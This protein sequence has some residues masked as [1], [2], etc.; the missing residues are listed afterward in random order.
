MQ[1]PAR[2]AAADDSRAAL[3][4]AAPS[5]P[6]NA[7]LAAPQ[8]AASSPA[9]RSPFF[10]RKQSLLLFPTDTKPVSL[11]LSLPTPPFFFFFS[12]F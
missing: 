1:R 11:S 5:A 7:A 4:C 10:K 12:F 3:R 8:N 9:P 2:G 6:L